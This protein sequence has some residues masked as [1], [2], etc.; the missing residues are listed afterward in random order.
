MRL[1]KSSARCRSS[2]DNLSLL[3]AMLVLSQGRRAASMRGSQFRK[4][5]P[6]AK[7]GLIY[8]KAH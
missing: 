6:V 8:A 7:S 3:C 4:R 2:S 5:R 1:E